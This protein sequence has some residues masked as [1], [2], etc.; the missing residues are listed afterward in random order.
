MWLADCAKV[1]VVLR[2]TG[3]FLVVASWW[4]NN[5]PTADIRSA[6]NNVYKVSTGDLDRETFP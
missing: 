4:G 3:G 5:V 2:I 6:E 1:L